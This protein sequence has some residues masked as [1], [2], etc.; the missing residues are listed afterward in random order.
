MRVE[1]L[2]MILTGINLGLLV[3]LVAA[4]SGGVAGQSAA[5]AVRASSIELVDDAG[6]VR[7]QLIVTPEGETLFRMRDAKGEVRTKLGASEEGSGLLLAD[8]STEPGL[9][10]LAKRGATT[11]TLSDR[12]GQQLVI[13]PADR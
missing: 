9:H 4:T 5:P 3:W 13:R 6:L 1:R 2:P 10:I 7:A 8:D 11:M 12:S